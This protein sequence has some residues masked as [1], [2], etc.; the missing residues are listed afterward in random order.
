M[1]VEWNRHY[2][3]I[4]HLSY[5]CLFL[6]CLFVL[7][8]YVVN[9][10]EY[11]IILDWRTLHRARQSTVVNHQQQQNTRADE[12]FRRRHLCRAVIRL[13][14]RE[15]GRV[16][17]VNDRRFPHR[18]RTSETD[19]VFTQPSH[20]VIDTSSHTNYSASLG[21]HDGLRRLALPAG[22]AQLQRGRWQHDSNVHAWW[23]TGFTH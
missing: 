15:R 10:D 9:K 21:R 17:S 4:F 8:Y 6:F 23:P 20:D 18:R 7:P 19:E 2:F 22:I 12:C 11:I 1:R 14:G 16:S 3:F 13:N 5:F